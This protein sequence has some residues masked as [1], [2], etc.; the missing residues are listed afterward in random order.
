MGAF[1]LDCSNAVTKFCSFGLT[2][3]CADVELGDVIALTHDL[4]G[5]EDKWMRVISIDDGENDAITVTCSEYVA[6]VYNDRAMDF[7]IHV[8]TNLPNPW[9][10]PDVIG[11]TGAERVT[12]D[13]DGTVLSDIDLFWTDPDVLLRSVEVLVL[14][15]GSVT[16]KSCGT[17]LPGI[18]NYVVRGLAS[19][20]LVSVMVRPVNTAGI[21]AVGKTVTLT[22]HGKAYPPAEPTEL[23]AVGG[24]QVVEISWRNPGDADLKHIEVWESKDDVQANA[25]K[26]ADVDGTSLTRSN[27]SNLTTFWYWIR[28][29]DTSGNVSGWVGPVSAT[30][31][32]IKAPDIPEG[33]I[34]PPML[35]DV[36]REPIERIPDI[37][38]DIE[39]INVE[40]GNIRDIT[41]PSIDAEIKEIQDITIPEVNINIRDSIQRLSE[42][43]SELDEGYVEQLR[44]AGS[45]AIRTLLQLRVLTKNSL[46]PGS[47]WTR[48]PDRFGYGLSI[49]SE[50]STTSVCPRQ[51]LPS[52][53]WPP[54]STARPVLP[55]WTPG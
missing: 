52:T 42:R 25:Y 31:E 13:T 36:L 37:E 46:T 9:T 17:V 38:V 32:T 8:D 43:V 19:N 16:W 23:T 33:L 54:R 21:K 20:Q 49:S 15:A 3:S 40:V 45:G 24:F 4:P 10:C 51:R 12:V 14:E 55:M 27:L 35:S 5:W 18:G 34:D 7:P 39:D 28:S 2:L 53:L 50:T 47:S 44:Q 11:L 48:A 41:I 30:T 26:A 29:V 6:E 22:L 1:L